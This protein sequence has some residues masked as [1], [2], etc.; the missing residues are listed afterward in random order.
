MIAESERTLTY[1][2]KN[3]IV[4][5]GS[6]R[7]DV[8]KLFWRLRKS[9]VD[10]IWASHNRFPKDAL[11]EGF[12]RSFVCLTILID[13]LPAA[14]FGIYAE[15]FNG[16]RATIWLLASPELDKI[17]IRFLKHS[18]KFIQMFLGYYPHLSNFVDDRNKSSIEWLKF[19]GATIHEPKPYGA[20]KLPFRYFYFER[21]E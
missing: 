5:R 9:D 14:M 20:E 16:D 7:G 15:V 12:K 4:V 8:D 10:E 17:K 18:R 1:Y 21:G 13:D 3:G 6:L 2:K 19:C 11:R